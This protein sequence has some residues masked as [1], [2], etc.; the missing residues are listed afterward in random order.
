MSGHMVFGHVDCTTSIINI[1]QDGDATIFTFTKPLELQYAIVPQGTI[2]IDGI[3]LT[4]A[5]IKDNTF[6]V[7]IVEHTWQNTT[8]SHKKI[9]DCVNIEADMLAKYVSKALALQ[10]KQ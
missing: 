10:T 4:I 2:S 7:S 5:Q 3:S 1:V 8:I 6:S 9:N